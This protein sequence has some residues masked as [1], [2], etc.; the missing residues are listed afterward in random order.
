MLIDE[1]PAPFDVVAHDGEPEDEDEL[2]GQNVED[3]PEGTA[4]DYDQVI[5][6]FPVVLSFEEQEKKPRALTGP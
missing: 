6:T 1:D 5:E 4:E 2:D 3:F